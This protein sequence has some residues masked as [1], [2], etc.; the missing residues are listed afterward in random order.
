MKVEDASM[1]TSACDGMITVILPSRNRHKCLRRV[2]PTY[3]SHAN[4]REV[5]IVDDASDPPVALEDIWNRPLQWDGP[6]VRIHRL[7]H[8]HGQPGA[9]NV[10]ARLASTEWLLYS[11]DDVF[12]E[13]EYVARLAASQRRTGADVV[14]GRRLYLLEG[15]DR[16]SALRRCANLSP[17]PYDPKL[18]MLETGAPVSGDL[19]VLHMQTTALIR[20]SLA[21]EIG[22][23]EG[24]PP[25]SYRE[26]TD[27]Y[28]NAARAGAKLILCGDAVCYHLPPSDTAVGGQRAD[29]WWRYEIGVVKCNHRF[30]GRHYRFLS[31]QRAI[32]GPRWLAE[33]RFA[34]WRLRGGLARA[35]Y[36]WYYHSHL[37]PVV[38]RLLG[39][40]PA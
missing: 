24:Y 11:D 4:V 34:D 33:L 6:G 40:S 2:L 9:R 20:R 15:E 18:F 35:M 19:P 16:V 27:F 1:R 31:E 38:R 8:R 30:L 32:A 13:E 7:P 36:R 14:A 5:L 29:R 26:E 10:A 23:Y 22:W 39:R 12:L 37:R 3:L 25:P 21:M 17:Q 28:L